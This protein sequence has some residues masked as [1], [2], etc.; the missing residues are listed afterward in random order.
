HRAAR[1]EAGI[2]I[3]DL[4]AVRRDRAAWRTVLRT[5]VRILACGALAVA[6]HVPSRAFGA[7]VRIERRAIAIPAID[8]DAATHRRSDP[9]DRSGTGELPEVPGRPR[10]RDVRAQRGRVLRVPQ[11]GVREVR[12]TDE[13][14][15]ELPAGIDDRLAADRRGHVIDP[16]VEVG[17]DLCRR[18]TVV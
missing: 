15:P 5:V 16:D 17:L 1:L 9:G 4:A 6:A 10:H 2:S 13:V 11:V 8:I 7:E 3:I 14:A 12:A 18:L